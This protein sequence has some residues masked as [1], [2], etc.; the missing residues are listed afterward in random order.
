M[1]TYNEF[2]SELFLYINICCRYS[3][4]A[5]RIK[6]NYFCIKTYVVDTH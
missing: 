4:E 5:P 2:Q 1:S 6:V 3:L